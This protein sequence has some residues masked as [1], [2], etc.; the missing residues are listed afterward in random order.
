MSG[1][2][3]MLFGGKKTK[4]TAINSTMT[5]GSQ[6]YVWIFPTYYLDGWMTN[7]SEF[8]YGAGTMGSM[9]APGEACAL[10]WKSA[11]NHSINGQ[12]WIEITG[13][14]PAGFV[15]QVLSNSVS[16]GTVTY[17][18]YQTLYNTTL[19]SVGAAGVA[20]PFGT[21]GTKTIAIT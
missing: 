5:V 17:S 4:V 14:V 3:M 8:F 16:L 15:T 2:S 18:G 10:Y 21:S 7:S 20:N 13:D 6:T 19:F 9:T 12:V 1:I 11:N